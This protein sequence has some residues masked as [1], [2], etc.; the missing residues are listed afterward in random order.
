MGWWTVEMIDEFMIRFFVM[1]IGR[2]RYGRLLRLVRWRTVFVDGGDD[3]FIFII[4]FLS[5]S[6][7]IK[8]TI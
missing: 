2:S 5:I 1:F 4:F 6:L 7:I 3:S 8:L